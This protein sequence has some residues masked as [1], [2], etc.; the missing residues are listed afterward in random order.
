MAVF[1][2]TATL[3]Y[4]NNVINS[5]TVTGELQ[6]VLSLTKLPVAD[7]YGAGDTVG[8]IVSVVNSGTTAFTN[9]TLT[10]NL[11][12]YIYNS[13]TL[14][15]LSY[16]SGSLKYYINGT[17]QAAPEVAAGPPLS[18]SGITVPAGGNATIIYQAKVNEYA[19]LDIEA[20]IENTV[21][22][23]G[24]GISTPLS[25]TAVISAAA[26]GDLSITKSICPSVITENGVLTYTFT[27]QNYGNTA[28]TAADNAV[29]TDSFD[30]ILSDLTAK[31]NGAAWTSETDYTYDAATGAFATVAG[32][33]TVPAATYRRDTDGKLI[34]TPGVSI[35]TVTG[36]V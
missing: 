22:I 32:R 11:G 14:Y 27:V 8:Y 21:T 16:V 4:N 7:T 17:I 1:T 33:L 35:L 19:P 28:I 5:N 3:S 36:T 25:D 15:P 10:D 9:L 26:A 12:E 18:V 31:F 23:T 13:A 24:R 20:Q 29:I 30:P 6:E 34:L 2:N